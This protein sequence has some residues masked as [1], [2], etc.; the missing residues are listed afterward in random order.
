MV[1]CGTQPCIPVSS[2]DDSCIRGVDV[3]GETK[4]HFQPDNHDKYGILVA[5]GLLAT[6]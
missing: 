3:S 6:L 5:E 2:Y 1:V 4:E